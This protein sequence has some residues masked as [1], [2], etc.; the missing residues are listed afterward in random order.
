MDDVSVPDGQVLFTVTQARTALGGIGK[1]TIYKLMDEG[2]LEAVKLGGRTMV[3][4]DSI[5]ALPARLAPYKA[6]KDPRPQNQ[7][8]PDRQ[9]SR[10]APIAGAE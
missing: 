1:E 7:P 5:R 6:G 4:A 3:R 2:W 10:R 8:N 9:P